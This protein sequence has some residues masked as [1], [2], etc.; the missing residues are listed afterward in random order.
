[1]QL[2][3]GQD[4]LLQEMDG[5]MDPIK[6]K[7]NKDFQFLSIFMRKMKKKSP[8]NKQGPKPSKLTRCDMKSVFKQT[9][10]GLNLEFFFLLDWLLYQ[11]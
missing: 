4:T 2:C 7:L 3:V 6:N 8:K 1:M 10:A 5:W 9:V 11:N